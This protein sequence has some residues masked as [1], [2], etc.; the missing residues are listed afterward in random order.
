MMGRYHLDE[1]AGLH[2]A[3]DRLAV[4]WACNFATARDL[5]E[6]QAVADALIGGLQRKLGRSE[7][8]ELDVRFHDILY[9]ASGHQRLQE[10][11]KALRPEVREILLSCDL[12]QER[13]RDSIADRNQRILEAIK[14]RDQRMARE[15]TEAFEVC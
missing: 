5:G 1:I 13:F 6:L 11:W 14:A 10:C 4:E 3:F 12:D 15:A 8:V 7:V 9:R 2:Q